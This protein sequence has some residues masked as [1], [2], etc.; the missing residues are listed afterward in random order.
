MCTLGD[1]RELLNFDDIVIQCHNAPDADTIA[2]GF[3]IQEYLK[4]HGKQAEI[5]YGE[6]LGFKRVAHFSCLNPWELKSINLR[7]PLISQSIC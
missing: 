6:Q 5:V 7:N 1:L 2:S 3:A 4:H